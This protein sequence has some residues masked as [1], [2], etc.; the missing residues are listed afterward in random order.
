MKALRIAVCFVTFALGAAYADQQEDSD[1]L[2]I[3]LKNGT[4]TQEQYDKLQKETSGKEN[5]QVDIKVT[6]EGGIQASTYDGKFSFK[7]GGSFSSDMAFYNE[8]KNPLGNGTE[9]RSARIELEGILFSNWNYEYSMDFAGSEVEIKD[10]LIAYKG[11]A[12]LDLK[13]GQFKVPF[14]M[15]EIGSRKYSTF[16][17][18]GLPNALA[19]DRKIGVGANY[20]GNLWT[21]TA[22]VFGN[23]YNQDVADEG[24]EGWMTSGRFTLVP[25]HSD[26]RIFHVGASTA[27]QVPNDDKEVRFRTR[28]ESHLTNVYYPNTG[29]IKKVQNTI[30][31]GIES[32]MVY[33]P[34]S[35]QGEYIH[36][37]VNREDDRNPA[38]N[39]GYVFG[40]WMI[41]GESRNYHFKKGAFGRIK[42]DRSYGAFEL[43]IRYSVLDLNSAPVLYGGREDNVTLAFN[44]YLNRNIKVMTNYVLINNDHHATDNGDLYAN[45]DIGVFQARLQ[46]EF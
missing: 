32:A 5:H 34:F 12:S 44:W 10:A 24:D 6:T 11:F 25:I 37:S 7:L 18:R 35:V 15:E 33:G 8:D 17:E 1:L 39:G 23:A 28:P 31:Y 14:S 4:I 45:D 27:Y 21:A 20:Y 22:G 46:I 41:T 2:I 43:A 36:S 40:S 19:F 3:L 26:T 16:M 42:P 29:K 13:I 9:I 38:F 30:T